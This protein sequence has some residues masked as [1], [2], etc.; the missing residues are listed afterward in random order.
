ML[1]KLSHG[2]V[3]LIGLFDDVR[4]AEVVAQAAEDVRVLDLEVLVETPLR[5]K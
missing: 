4:S 3:F 5:P 1:P 2:I